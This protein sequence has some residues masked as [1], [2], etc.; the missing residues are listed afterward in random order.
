MVEA[1]FATKTSSIN[2]NLFLMKSK[3]FIFQVATCFLAMLF[4]LHQSVSA[5]GP[6]QTNET[7]L[8]LPTSP[9]PLRSDSKI[10]NT[11]RLTNVRATFDAIPAEAHDSGFMTFHKPKNVQSGVHDHIQG[12]ATN[13]EQMIFSINQKGEEYGVFTFYDIATREFVTWLN[14]FPGYNHPAGM[15]MTGN[16]FVAGM[17]NEDSK[18]NMVIAFDIDGGNV[19]ELNVSLGT[20]HCPS[21]GITD[22]NLQSDG[23]FQYLLLV[24]GDG[25]A[26][27]FLSERTK[28]GLSKELPFKFV[29]H[30]PGSELPHLDAQGVQLL[31][32]SDGSVFAISFTTDGQYITF[33]DYI[34]LFSL[35]GAL[36][37]D[38]EVKELAH[39]H[40]IAG[41]PN[42][43]PTDKLN[44]HCR[45]GTGIEVGN[46]TLTCYVSGR[47]PYN[48]GFTH[49]EEGPYV[50]KFVGTG[51]QTKQATSGELSLSTVGNSLRILFG[52]STSD[53]LFL[54]TS[55]DGVSWPRSHTNVG[56]ATRERPASAVFN[57]SYFIA[58]KSSNSDD[59]YVLQS[60]RGA[61]KVPT[62][63]AT[64]KGVAMCE[65]NN[66]L[67][68]AFKS[69]NSDDIFVI[70]SEDGSNWSEHVATGQ[71]TKESVAMC[72][73][74]GK[75]FITFKSSSSD[76]L[77]VIS[78][79]DGEN[80]S[81]NVSTNQATDAGMAICEHNSQLYL[82]FKS[83]NSDDIYY[84]SSDDGTNWSG[85]SHSGEATKTSV[86]MSSLEN[87]LWIAFKSSTDDLLKCIPISGE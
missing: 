42:H 59:I 38:L 74:N 46:E 1:H 32:Q 17:Q 62:G 64:N 50:D 60:K 35:T 2:I 11:L 78:S 67:Y 25:G 39:K 8:D 57:K 34:N 20:Q 26:T 81:D 22:V 44:P 13:G 85:P 69:S 27:F 16:F 84:I 51:G 43:G 12:I 49:L 15:Q 37:E 36:D 6:R 52:S 7:S 47:Q 80:W 21:V 82:A 41:G 10:R 28:T 53:G 77:L 54:I 55:K 72:E 40:V 9:K 76:D 18:E 75:L 45:Y 4:F 70:S 63:Q 48:H 61:Q 87:Y 19:F 83:S 68:I 23:S 24:S 79:E 86:S 3:R 31:T 73:Y 14:M 56:Q 66:R 5:Q 30:F 29:K 58:F 71:A 65:F 33:K